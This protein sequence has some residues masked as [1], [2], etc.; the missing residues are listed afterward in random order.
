MRDPRQTSARSPRGTRSQATHSASARTSVPCARAGTSSSG[1][2]PTSTSAPC[3][4][5]RGDT[6][7]CA[8]RGRSPGARGVFRSPVRRRRRDRGWD[9]TSTSARGAPGAGSTHT[10]A[11]RRFGRRRL[12]ARGAVAPRAR[13]GPSGPSSRWQPLRA[14]SSAFRSRSVRAPARPGAPSWLIERLSSRPPPR[15]RP[16]HPEQLMPQCP[17]AVPTRAPTLPAPRQ[18]FSARVGSWRLNRRPGGRRVKL[19]RE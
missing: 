5:G 7:A 11:S 1:E 16:P 13:R 2:G 6:K 15:R 18:P 9:A 8:R 10:L 19:R 14:S 4:W 12:T 17:P 3:A